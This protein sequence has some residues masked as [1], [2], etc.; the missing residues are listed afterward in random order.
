[1]LFGHTEEGSQ[2]GSIVLSHDGVVEDHCVGCVRSSD[3]DVLQHLCLETQARHQA[4]LCVVEV[5]NREEG[6]HTQGLGSEWWMSS[7]G[8]VRVS[9]I[10]PGMQLIMRAA[11]WIAE[12]QNACGICLSVR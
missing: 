10:L 12:N 9:A 3:G 7:K 6:N 2:V 4:I 5:P 1:M 11:C 8:V